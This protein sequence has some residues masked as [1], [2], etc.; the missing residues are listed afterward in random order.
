MNKAMIV[1][2]LVAFA[3]GCS[4]SD[5]ASAEEDL[6]TVALGIDTNGTTLDI[7]Y[8]QSQSIGFVGRY[9]SFDG[10]HPALTAVEAQRFHDAGMPLVLIWEVDQQRAFQEQSIAGQHANG[11]QDA[12]DA[13]TA[14]QAAGAAGQV[15]YFTVDFDVTDALWSSTFEDSKTGNTI[16][17]GDLIVSYFK[18][19][20][21]VIGAART[22]AY[23]TYTVLHE[24]FDQGRIKYGWQ[25]TFGNHAK[26][27]RDK[28]AQLRQYAFPTD[29][30]GWGVSGAGALDLDRAVHAKY[31]QWL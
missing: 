14:L 8:A 23:G 12:N 5:T 19:I 2:M 31:G 27:P 26:D 25:Q 30:S 11:A 4:A 3:T 28:R 29:Q 10:A 7:G 15:V 22:G 1:S 20:D 18:G 24:L 9:I 6:S 16:T 21:S 13:K 17:V